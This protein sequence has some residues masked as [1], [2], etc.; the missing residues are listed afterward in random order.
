MNAELVKSALQGDDEALILCL[1]SITDQLTWTAVSLLGDRE[2]AKDC[3]METT[4]KVYKKRKTVKKPEFFKTWVIRILINECKDE[5]K[6]SKN[7]IPLDEHFEIASSERENFDY[8]N[9]LVAKLPLD[10][11]Q[12]IV[13]KFFDEMNFREIGEVLK[14]PEST[15]KSRYAVAL[16]KLRME[17]EEYEQ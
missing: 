10:L 16:K 2:L 12:I 13:L 1:Q 9:D 4:L 17:M 5:L 6:R 3:I 14:T 7:Y 8:V 11:K 15:V